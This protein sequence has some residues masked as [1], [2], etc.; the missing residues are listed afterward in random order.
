MIA[1]GTPGSAKADPTPVQAAE[2]MQHPSTPTTGANISQNG[3]MTMDGTVTSDAEVPQDIPQRVPVVRTERYCG[4]ISWIIGITIFP[5]I[6]LC[7][8]DERQVVV[9]QRV[10][11]TPSGSPSGSPSADSTSKKVFEE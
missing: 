5:W 9:E 8:I 2:A 10:K 3:N 4:V 7:P 1:N 6:C 11:R